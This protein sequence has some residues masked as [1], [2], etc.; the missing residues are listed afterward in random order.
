MTFVSNTVKCQPIDDCK[1]FAS[2]VNPFLSQSSTRLYES[3]FHVF[4]QIFLQNDQNVLV[5]CYNRHRNVLMNP[6]I[7]IVTE[8]KVL[9]FLQQMLANWK[10]HIVQIR[11]KVHR[12]LWPQWIALILPQSKHFGHGVDV[13]IMQKNF[14]TTLWQKDRKLRW[15]NTANGD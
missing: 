13:I 2:A 5:T 9:C 3:N 12:R 6:V 14:K 11:T 8:V 1:V 7:V 4:D 15:L 10:Y